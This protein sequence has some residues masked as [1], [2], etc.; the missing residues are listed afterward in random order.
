MPLSSPIQ[1]DYKTRLVIENATP[2]D[3]SMSAAYANASDWGKGNAPAFQ[4]VAL[5]SR[6][7]VAR[8]WIV[9]GSARSAVV[10][11]TFT[12]QLDAQRSASI[13]ARIDQCDAKTPPAALSDPDGK[14]AKDYL[15]IAE[16]C[17]LSDVIVY[18]DVQCTPPNAFRLLQ[19]VSGKDGAYLNALTIVNN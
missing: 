17:H 5:P 15:Q 7:S 14:S 13:V 6:Q 4:N 8:E 11:V 16:D 9:A 2:H 1:P 12:T 19:F 3:M 10:V 18:A